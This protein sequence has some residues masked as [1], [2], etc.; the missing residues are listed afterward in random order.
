MKKKT[1][2]FSSSL[3]DLR[4]PPSPTT[5]TYTPPLLYATVV[6]LFLPRKDLVVKDEAG[7][8]TGLCCKEKHDVFSSF[9][10]ETSLFGARFRPRMK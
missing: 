9:C 4:F 1:V 10:S 2:V 8:S 7:F 3:S 5:L 6:F